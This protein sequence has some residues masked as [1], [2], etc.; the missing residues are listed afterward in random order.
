MDRHA[1]LRSANK[2]H[3]RI[4]VKETS[5]EEKKLKAFEDLEEISEDILRKRIPFYTLIVNRLKVKG[6]CV[7][8]FYR[9]TP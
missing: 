2:S 3:P 5:Y 7:D 6:L 9:H 1:L 4:T 8:R